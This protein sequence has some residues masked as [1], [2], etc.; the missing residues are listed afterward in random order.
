MY[1][2]LSDVNIH[3]LALVRITGAVTPLI[4]NAQYHDAS[5]FP[6]LFI[7]KVIIIHSVQVKI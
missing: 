6:L 1:N 4:K 2:E 3:A 7:Q 5:K